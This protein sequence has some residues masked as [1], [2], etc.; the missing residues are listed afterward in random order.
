MATLKVKNRNNGV[1]KAMAIVVTPDMKDDFILGYPQ[2]KELE[3]ISNNFPMASY[4]IVYTNEFENIK[5]S[6]SDEYPTT[7][8]D[9]LPK[10]AMHMTPTNRR[11]SSPMRQS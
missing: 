9:S 4:S 2:L 7:I 11:S 8:R 3:V 10:H 6:I 5:K 1:E